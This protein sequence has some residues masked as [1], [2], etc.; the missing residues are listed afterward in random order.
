MKH[1]CIAVPLETYGILM[2]MESTRKKLLFNL[3]LTF[4]DTRN[5]SF[6]NITLDCLMMGQTNP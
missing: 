4:K 2:I 1:I 6:Y 5:P 3:R